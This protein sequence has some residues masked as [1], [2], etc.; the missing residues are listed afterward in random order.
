[1]DFGSL[2][3]EKRL[4]AGIGLRKF[5]KLIGEL[6]SNLSAVETGARA[7]WRSISKLRIVADALAIAEGSREWDSF[8]LA[9]RPRDMLPEEIDKLLERDLAVSMLRT[10]DECQLSDAQLEALI[11]DIRNGNIGNVR[12]RSRKRNS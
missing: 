6:P 3:R 12:R 2:L 9:A 11:E 1:M 7:P 10:V 5:A 8:F 4:R